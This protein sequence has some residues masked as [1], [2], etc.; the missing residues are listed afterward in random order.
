MPYKTINPNTEKE[1]FAIASITNEELAVKLEL[2]KQTC[3]VWTRTT[4]DT[5]AELMTRFSDILKENKESLGQLINTEMGCETVQA[6][7]EVMK[8]A[9]IA[10]IFANNTERMLRAEIIKS[11]HTQS[12]IQFDPLGVLFHIAPWNYPIYL[13]LRPVIPAIMAGNCVVMKHASNVP[14]IAIEL[15]KL[16]LAAGFP[17]GVFQTLL[18]DVSQVEQVISHEKVAVVTLIGSERAGSSVAAIAGKHLKKTVMELGGNDPMLVYD[19]ADTTA[20]ID[21]IMASRLRNA[22]QSCNAP[23][24]IIM[25]NKIKDQFIVD[26]R[27]RME[28]FVGSPIATSGARDGL[29]EQ[30]TKSVIAGAE[31]ELG[32]EFIVGKTGFHYQPTILSNVRPGMTAFEEEIF[33]PV[34]SIITAESE[35]EILELANNSKYGLGASIWTQRLEMAREL[36]TQVEAGN[37]YVNSIVRGDPKMPF[38][39]V[40][41]TGYGREFGEYGIKEFVNIKSVVWK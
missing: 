25:T 37:V 26:L 9:L 31:L 11:D 15:E 21:G 36:I 30:V 12:Y 18:I 7:A 1:E 17:A 14:Q 32:G 16:F 33:G 4:M 13:A 38:G 34:V 23:K 22:G 20:V 27:R 5:R 29:H 39:G 24:R 2:A 8:T 3:K 19:D 35:D 28:C 6:E 41:L 10:E 40:K